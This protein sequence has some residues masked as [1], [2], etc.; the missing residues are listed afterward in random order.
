MCPVLPE[1]E[2]VA[3]DHR[4]V[5]RTGR[6]ELLVAGYDEARRK[7]DA[8]LEVAGGYV[9]STRVGRHRGAVSEAT[10]SV[11]VPSGAFAGLLPRLAAIGEVTIELTTR[12]AELAEAAPPSLGAQSSSALRASLDAMWGLARG[13]AV[14]LVALLPWLLLVAAP[15]YLAVRAMVR[16]SRRSLPPAIARPPVAAP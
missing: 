2:P 6:V 9:D 16:R 1:R 11:R 7:L 15:I 3:A 5:V 14:A 4:K 12:R 10:L 8:L 13:L